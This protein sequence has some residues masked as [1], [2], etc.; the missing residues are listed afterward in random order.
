MSLEGDIIIITN[1]NR[2]FDAPL[3]YK[4][5]LLDEV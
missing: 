3:K 2:W 5:Q 4:V 1:F